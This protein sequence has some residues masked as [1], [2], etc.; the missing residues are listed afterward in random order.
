MPDVGLH[1]TL[2]AVRVRNA[3]NIL[4][5]T[6]KTICSIDRIGLYVLLLFA[7]AN[8]CIADSVESSI[9]KAAVICSVI[10]GHAEIEQKLLT[11]S[12]SVVHFA[13]GNTKNSPFSTTGLKEEHRI[14]FYRNKELVRLEYLD[15]SQQNSKENERH[16]SR[17]LLAT[18]D[19][20][21]VFY[22]ISTTGSAYANIT[23]YKSPSKEVRISLNNNFLWTIECLTSLSGGNRIVDLLQNK[24][25]AVEFKRFE[26]V[27]NALWVCCE[28]NNMYF[29]LVMDID[30]HY[31]LTYSKA[32]SKRDA[33][34]LVTRI[35]SDYS[36]NNILY[37]A[38]TE[39]V[40]QSSV[41]P[42]NRHI[43]QL[44][45]DSTDVSP[46][47]FTEKSIA[48]M[49]DKFSAGIVKVT[50]QNTSA[51]ETSNRLGE[52]TPD[53]KSGK[54]KKLILV[55]AANFFLLMMFYFLFFSRKKKTNTDTQ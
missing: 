15:I 10:E 39:L 14:R 21:F 17:I 33:T 5:Y 36:L 24:I 41:F 25:T 11:V 29:E 34:A 51:K 6:M 1:S 2:A 8:P 49:K 45:I 18:P 16:I 54:Y 22:P 35:R 44:A 52:I 38:E 4:E 43:T 47:L 31:A 12:G 9:D 23:K 19:N 26:D 40:I 55:F 3:E 50:V 48:E 37:P 28:S 46:A 53:N 20:D 42:E 7:A 30:K 27:N 13:G 32:Y